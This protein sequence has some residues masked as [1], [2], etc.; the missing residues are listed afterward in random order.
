MSSQLRWRKSLLLIC[1]VLKLFLDALTCR[2]K[3]SLPNID[4][5][6]QPFKMELSQKQQIFSTFLFAVLKSTLNVEHFP[7]KEVPHS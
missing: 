3:Y 5:L 6:Q 4:H 2:D 1:K 7:K